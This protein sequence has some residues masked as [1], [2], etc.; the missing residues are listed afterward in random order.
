MAT[1]IRVE[2]GILQQAADC[3]AAIARL[4][5][6]AVAR[7]CA[8]DLS[9]LLNF[10][11]VQAAAA[12]FAAMQACSVLSKVPKSFYSMECLA[13]TPIDAPQESSRPS[14]SVHL[15]A[16][17]F[18]ETCA[19][20]TQLGSQCDMCARAQPPPPVN[21]S[22][23]GSSA[24]SG[25]PPGNQ[26]SEVHASEAISSE[27]SSASAPSMRDPPLEIGVTGAVLPASFAAPALPPL[28]ARFAMPTSLGG[29]MLDPNSSDIAASGLDEL[30]KSVGQSCEV[31]EGACSNL[32]NVV[33]E[34]HRRGITL[35]KPSVFESAMK[36]IAAGYGARAAPS[37]EVLRRYAKTLNGFL[38]MPKA[39]LPDNPILTGSLPAWFMMGDE[40]ACYDA[41]EWWHA[42]VIQD[43][44]KGGKKVNVFWV[45]W[46]ESTAGSARSSKSPG[47]SGSELYKNP[48]FVNRDAVRS[49][50]DCP[51]VKCGRL[52]NFS[53]PWI[54][55][56]YCVVHVEDE[57]EESAAAND[58]QKAEADE[59]MPAKADLKNRAAADKGKAAKEAEVPKKRAAT[60]KN[61]KVSRVAADK[62]KAAKVAKKRAVTAKESNASRA[63]RA[64]KGAL[65]AKKQKV[66]PDDDDDDDDD[67]DDE[68]DDDDDDDDDNNDDDDDHKNG[69]V[70]DPAASPTSDVPAQSF[71]VPM[72]NVQAHSA[73]SSFQAASQV[74]HSAK[75]AEIC[76][77]KSE[78]VSR[79][80]NR[81]DAL[82]W[83]QLSEVKRVRAVAFFAKLDQDLSFFERANGHGDSKLSAE[84][85]SLQIQKEG[86]YFQIE[87][88]DQA[89]RNLVALQI[90][91][92][93]NGGKCWVPGNLINYFL[94]SL[95]FNNEVCFLTVEQC[96]M[97]LERVPEQWSQDLKQ[98]S[99]QLQNKKFKLVVGAVSLKQDDSRF[100]NADNAGYHWILIIG[101]ITGQQSFVYDPMNAS[102]TSAHSNQVQSLD[103]LMGTQ[104]FTRIQCP[105]KLKCQIDSVHCGVWCM[106]FLSN[107]CLGSLQLYEEQIAAQKP[108]DLADF[109][110]H[111]KQ[112]FYY[113]TVRHGLLDAAL[114]H[115]K[116]P[117]ISQ[118]NIS[119]FWT[120]T[121]ELAITAILHK[122]H[123]SPFE[124]YYAGKNNTLARLVF[125][126]P[127][128][129]SFST[130]EKPRFYKN[131][132]LCVKVYRFLWGKTNSKL[133]AAALHEVAAT[134]FICTQKNWYFD[135][136]GVVST[137]ISAIYVHLCI[138]R[139]ELSPMKNFTGI[140]D[141]ASPFLDLFETTG[142]AHG[143]PHK[144]NVLAAMA[145]GGK[146]T[147]EV[148]DCERSFF[149]SRGIELSD[150]AKCMKSYA[151]VGADL[152]SFLPSIEQQGLERTRQH[153]LTIAND[154]LNCKA[155]LFEL[156]LGATKTFEASRPT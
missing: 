121:P 94:G 140:T 100:R 92:P 148:V 101:D 134:A 112:M 84:P 83:E 20:C 69:S 124:Q 13:S 60:P 78:D 146:L 76:A 8:A 65:A 125:T 74:R 24:T 126:G 71:V 45:G 87:H 14:D 75:A 129:A 86:S 58:D 130:T 154:V 119:P 131:G 48:S 44:P 39:L 7:L 151:Q 63:K 27:A 123:G 102:D 31:L 105:L 54:H 38:L 95:V 2:S 91:P 156:D 18:V 141:H 82:P 55:K 17:Q 115:F 103:L 73:S 56:H 147:I 21:I 133:L 79:V 120:I 108:T 107:F 51:N 59:A 6:Q 138:C 152:A 145:D 32:R 113:D 81:M 85:V 70:V 116:S 127:L 96:D 132:M 93:V 33:V 57:S 12:A 35:N 11:T 3:R 109:A 135:V 10:G 61:S 139:R 37:D 155:N 19:A 104:Y 64:I 1:W 15:A 47:S 90:L 50:V 9:T 99:Q 66:T 29:S 41:G 34:L 142:V 28:S 49:F 136:F 122:R 153:F 5:M 89:I 97:L 137:G 26:P 111:F 106:M 16:D 144:G 68:D 118:L 36:W 98:L 72:I 23:G 67:N 88:C 114:M 25:S 77:L 149:P 150:V 42:V 30:F 4:P 117:R 128:P 53:V 46:A 43:I 143:D 110:V 62:A 80:S 52:G 40:V 22:S